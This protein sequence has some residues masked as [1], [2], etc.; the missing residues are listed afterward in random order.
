V[1]LPLAPGA[2]SRGLLAALLLAGALACTAFAALGGWQ[3]RRLAWKQD[4]IARVESHLRAAPVAAPA[5]AAWGALGRGD[6]YRRVRLRGRYEHE[7]ETAVRA[8]TALGG[9]YWILTPMLCE[10]G[11]RVLVNRGFVPAE[12]R[13]RATRAAQEPAGMQELTGLLRFS[14]PGGSL[15]QRNDPVADRWVSRDVQAIA[16]ARGLQRAVPSAPPAP[17]F[18]D[19][20][21]GSPAAWPRGGLT[22]VRFSNNHLVYAV[23]WFALA[24]MTAGAMAYL[25]VDARRRSAGERPLAHDRD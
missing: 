16:A 4:L 2:R 13:P 21:A 9:G 20:E 24:L 14:E 23:T 25:V 12:L 6:E 22:V 8:V 7:R 18:V 10:G 3:L 1:T 5:P 15:L 17:Y 11:F 19:A